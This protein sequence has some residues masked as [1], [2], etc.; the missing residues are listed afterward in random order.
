MTNR[1][2]C[3]AFPGPSG[4]DKYT[5][6][7]IREHFASLALQGLCANYLRENVSGWSNKTYAVEAVSLADALIEE[8][9]RTENK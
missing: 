4:S 9:E 7:T 5:G 8:L 6:L 1:K 3:S 2:D